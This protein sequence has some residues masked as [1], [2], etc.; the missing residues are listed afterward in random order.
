MK[1]RILSLALLGGAL[2]AA[3]GTFRKPAQEG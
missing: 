3:A 2:T 1:F